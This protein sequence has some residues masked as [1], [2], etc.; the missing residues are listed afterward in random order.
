MLQRTASAAGGAARRRPT[1]QRRPSAAR[2]AVVALALA[3]LAATGDPGVEISASG[4]RHAGETGTCHARVEARAPAGFHFAER[5]PATAS[6]EA[7]TR[8]EPGGDPR[9]T[10]RFSLVDPRTL[11]F[12]WTFPHQGHGV[13]RG[14]AKLGVCSD[15]DEICLPRTASFS[16]RD[17]RTGDV[18]VTSA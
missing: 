11:V 8:P 16:L 10:R 7:L 1:E 2:G 18:A 6:L 3:S 5:Y 15:A 14:A 13:L 9:T 17:C 12:D 4:H